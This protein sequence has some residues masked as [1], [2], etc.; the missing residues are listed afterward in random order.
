MLNRIKVNIKAHGLSRRFEVRLLIHSV[1]PCL[2]LSQHRLFHLLGLKLELLVLLLMA[3]LEHLLPLWVSI[4]L[5]HTVLLIILVWLLMILL[6]RLIDCKLVGGDKFMFF[7][8]QEIKT[9]TLDSPIWKMMLLTILVLLWEFILIRIF[10]DHHVLL[11]GFWENWRGN[12]VDEYLRRSSGAYFIVEFMWSSFRLI[13]AVFR[14]SLVSGVVEVLVLHTRVLWFRQLWVRSAFINSRHNLDIGNVTA[15][16][17]RVLPRAQADWLRTSDLRLLG[18]N[19]RVIGSGLQTDREP[20]FPVE[21]EAGYL[22]IWG[23][24][25]WNNNLL[26]VE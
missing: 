4:R 6:L 3:S 24:A 22:S 19:W 26:F 21:F 9:L 7:I 14:W 17:D 16:L 13:I 10:L 2:L 20:V 18:H 11:E 8:C 5:L 25:V 12:W 23:L 1:E 15:R